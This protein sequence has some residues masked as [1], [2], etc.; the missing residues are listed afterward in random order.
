MIKIEN[1]STYGFEAAVRGMRN[2]LNSWDKSDSEFEC[3]FYNEELAMIDSIPCVSIGKN[4]LD[5][6]KK[7]AKA[8][9]D[10]GKYLR[11][12]NVTMDITAPLYWWK[13]F[14]T[15]KVG[16]VRNSC[17]TMHKI[18]SRDLTIEDFSAEH[19]LPGTASILQTVIDTINLCR[20]KYIREDDI[21]YWYQMIQLL[22]SSYNQRSTVQLNYE[23]LRKMYFARKNHKLDE[24][25]EF[26]EV[27]EEL[28]YFREIFLDEGKSESNIP[29]ENVSELEAA[30]YT[31]E[32]IKRERFME[33]LKKGNLFEEK[34]GVTMMTRLPGGIFLPRDSEG[35]EDDD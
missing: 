26:C 16:T 14:D 1:I 3:D 29:A 21:E 5:L 2:P 24:W 22:P 19:L 31:L 13:E 10:H 34:D 32:E 30:V 12:I 28:P 4:D 35:G 7:L 11:M 23:V 25:H 15:Y 8:G 18:H 27:V 20:G 9:A 6:M 17:S 33:D